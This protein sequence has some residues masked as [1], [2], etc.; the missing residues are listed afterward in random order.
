MLASA[1]AAAMF[2]ATAGG[3]VAIAGGVLM[4]AYYI[5]AAFHQDAQTERPNSITAVS[6]SDRDENRN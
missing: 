5:G 6:D 3:A 2:G 1:A 4:G